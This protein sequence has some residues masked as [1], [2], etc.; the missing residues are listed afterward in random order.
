[1][2]LALKPQDVFSV[3]LSGHILTGHAVKPL[4]EVLAPFASKLNSIYTKKMF[5]AS[6]D[7]GVPLQLVSRDF[8]ELVRPQL[9]S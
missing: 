2:I 6:T 4:A 5:G 1:M 8:S 7:S 3:D 9:E